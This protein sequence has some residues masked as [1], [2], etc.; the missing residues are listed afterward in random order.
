M[1]G[2]KIMQKGKILSK[3][4]RL[5][6]LPDCFIKH[7]G[8]YNLKS[9]KRKLPVVQKKYEKVLK[10]LYINSY[11][12]FETEKKD[13][14]I[15]GY[16]KYW[17][18]YYYKEEEIELPV[19]EYRGGMFYLSGMRKARVPTKESVDSANVLKTKVDE[20]IKWIQKINKENFLKQEMHGKPAACLDDENFRTPFEN[21]KLGDL[22]IFC[23]PKKGRSGNYLVVFDLK[24]IYDNDNDDVELEIPKDI[25]NH[26]L[27]KDNCNANEWI[28]TLNLGNIRVFLI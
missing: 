2:G 7:K 1:T 9:E 22:Y 20:R 11:S 18:E 27:G 8:N 15:T 3:A 19:Y 21:G 10:D 14:T 24:Q 25:V 16:Y 17:N 12:Y 13:G 28:D 5:N 4:K 6:D 26:I 23:I